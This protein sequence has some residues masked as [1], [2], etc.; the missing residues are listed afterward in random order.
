MKRKFTAFLAAIFVMAAFLPTAWAAGGQGWVKKNNNW[1]YY[2]DDSLTTGWQQIDGKR[3]Y[4][5][6]DGIM[7]VGWMK[8]ADGGTDL[9]WYFFGDSGAMMTGWIY[10]GTANGEPLWYYLQADGRMKTGW[11]NDAKDGKAR[12]YYLKPGGNMAIG[13]VRENA[14]WYLM[15]SSGLMMTGWVEWRSSRYYLQANGKMAKGT[16]VIDGK[17]Y[18]FRESG[19]LDRVIEQTPTPTPTATPTPTRTSSHVALPIEMEVIDLVNAERSRAGLPPLQYLPIAGEMARYKSKDMAD[20]GYYDHDSPT[21]GAWSN[22]A[23][24]FDF[25]YYAL[26]ENIAKGQSNAQRVMEAW[27]KSPDHKANILHDSFT[28]IGV[29]YYVDAKGVALWTQTF[30]KPVL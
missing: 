12:W 7:A 21:Y 9:H 4:F 1:L 5:R 22:L 28:H 26:G 18:V 8:L 2:K 13:W 15:D 16:H 27:M 20:N 11:L 10:D 25:K 30:C 17:T 14:D 19:E 24:L 23:K 6:H 3:Y 29:G